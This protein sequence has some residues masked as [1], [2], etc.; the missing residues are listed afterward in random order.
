MMRDEDDHMNDREDK[1]KVI[2]L[3]LD[4]ACVALVLLVLWFAFTL[5]VERGRYAI[6]FLGISFVISALRVLVHGR[7]LGIKG[8]WLVA[9]GLLFIGIFIAATAYLYF[10][11][12]DMLTDRAGAYTGVDVLVGAGIVAALFLLIWKEGGVAL[13]GLILL[14]LF[15]FYSGNHFPGILE[16]SGFSVRRIIEESILGFEG[17]YG[18]VLLTVSTWVAIFLIYAG[19][20]RGF[21]S[22]DTIVKG[23]TIVFSRR[24]SFIPQ[25]PVAASLI[26][27]SFSGSAT[28]N[29]A[30]TGSFTITIMK[31]FGIPPLQ[32]GAIESVASSGGQIMP[33]LMGATAFLIASFLGVSYLHIVVV[34]F[35][36]AFLFYLALAF[37]VYWRTAGHVSLDS[38]AFI[39]E[40]AWSKEDW[41][42]L[43]PLILSVGVLFTRLTL[44]TPM[45]RA[46]I[47][48][49]FV[50]VI[51]QLFYELT[52][53]LRKK[54]V[55]KIF[56]DF[57]V[58]LFN[59]VKGCA[60]PAASIGLI[61]AAMGFIVRVLTV[62]GLG[63]KLSEEL[64]DI[65]HG[66][67]PLL[68]FFILILCILFGMA[69]S[70]IAVYVL[71]TFVAAPA[72]KEMGIPLMAT[73]FM[74]FYL[75]NMSF[76]TPPVAPAA[77]VASGIA[78][79][80]FMPTA[81]MATRLGL[82]L[83]LLGINFVYRPELLIWSWQTPMA[84]VIVFIG[85][86]G[87]ASALH[88]PYQPGWRSIIE[89]AILIVGSFAAMF[90]IKT[91][92]YIP[93]AVVVLIIMVM[94]LRKT[95]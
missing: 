50:F 73:H 53:N 83:F 38:T 58:C 16:H 34:G 37:S 42:K 51:A 88:I 18:I 8:G 29:V 6:L 76:I 61:G 5:G 40:D 81:W 52:A 41:I 45:M 67:L 2:R 56:A 11:Y 19:I 89:R 66:I 15:Y 25:I 46:C 49:V 54:S 43:L 78:G 47:E 87:I 57:G 17:V 1:G 82:P 44:L 68:L 3:S 92:V 90:I 4:V 24:R 21:G 80:G 20:I 85:L 84:A 7:F 12:I 95:E 60:P 75:G 64:V 63:P 36:P 32:A 93:A 55:L 71:T 62:T 79:T 91:A 33:P 28:A 10:Q 13:F 48:G 9:P 22:L 30:G 72:L 86:C 14:F 35:L 70:T 94:R 65:S 23:C 59:G 77:L 26:F 39:K 74:I 31:R 69:V 27:G